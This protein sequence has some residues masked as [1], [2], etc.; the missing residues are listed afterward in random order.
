VE[1]S[2]TTTHQQL[3][4]LSP[5][6]ENRNN[7]RHEEYCIVQLEINTWNDTQIGSCC[8]DAMMIAKELSDYLSRY[9]HTNPAVLPSPQQRYWFDIRLVGAI[10]GMDPTLIVYQWLQ[11]LSQSWNPIMDHHCRDHLK[12]S[13]QI[14]DNDNDNNNPDQTSVTECLDDRTTT[15]VVGV[16][17]NTTAL[18][19]IRKQ[20]AGLLRIVAHVRVPED[21]TC[22]QWKD[23]NRIDKLYGA[24]DR[25]LLTMMAKHTMISVSIDIYTEESF[26]MTDELEFQTRYQHR[27]S[28]QEI[29]VHRGTT[30][31]LLQD[32]QCI[33]QTAHIFIPSASYLS[34]FCGYIIPPPG[35][36]V[37]SHPSRWQYFISCHELMQQCCWNDDDNDANDT[38]RHDHRCCPSRIIDLTQLSSSSSS[39]SLSDNATWKYLI[40]T[41][42]NP[43]ND[44]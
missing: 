4:Q 15:A 23:D 13:K 22:P 5:N 38:C 1:L 10:R 29:H 26:P 12:H 31:S 24:L 18:D 21:F 7:N 35:I 34:V 25:I 41:I 16:V 39:S 14:D 2:D 11:S 27:P 32:I 36:I 19:G 3:Q 6:N 33:V 44:I 28:V 17:C 37:L 40:S 42:E 30:E 8:G 43:K 20:S 9:H